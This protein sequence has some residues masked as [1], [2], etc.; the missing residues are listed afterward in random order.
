MSEKKKADAAAAADADAAKT[1]A[2]V[3]KITK[4]RPGDG[5]AST[6][7]KEFS[8]K[9]QSIAKGKVKETGGSKRRKRKTNKRKSKTRKSR[10][11]SRRKQKKV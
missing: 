9:F 1:A 8:E 10:R 3:Q 5:V 11:K 2:E 4:E 7:D 6:L